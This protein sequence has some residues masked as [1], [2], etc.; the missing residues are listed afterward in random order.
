MACR[1]SQLRIKHK[2]QIEALEARTEQLRARPAERS[3]R[4]PRCRIEHDDVMTISSL[5]S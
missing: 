5:Q 1:A 4:D 2:T 3:S